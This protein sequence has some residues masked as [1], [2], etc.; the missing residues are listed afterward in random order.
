[1]PGFDVAGFGGNIAFP[2]ATATTNEIHISVNAWSGNLDLDLI[3]IPAGFGQHFHGSALGP[4]KFSGSFN[5]KLQYNSAATS[6]FPIPAATATTSWASLGFK[7]TATFTAIDGCYYTGTFNFHSIRI[8]RPYSGYAEV[9][10]DFRN[11]DQDVGSTWDV[12]AP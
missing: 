5:G 10:G 4:A 12:I 7:G 6:P 2:T 3:E 11:Y 9:T 8:S 1:M